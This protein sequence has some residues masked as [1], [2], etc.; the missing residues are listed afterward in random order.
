MSRKVSRVAATAGAS[1]M[2]FWCRRCTEQSRPVEGN[3]NEIVTEPDD[4]GKM[5]HSVELLELIFTG[6]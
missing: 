2:I 1:S 5:K 3:D 6:G 4:E